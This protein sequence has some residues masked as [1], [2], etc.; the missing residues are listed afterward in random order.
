MVVQRLNPDLV[1]A[2]ITTQYDAERHYVAIGAFPMPHSLHL[3]CFTLCVWCTL[4]IGFDEARRYKVL[5]NAPTLKRPEGL[6]DD[7]DW[8]QYLE[9]NPDLVRAGITTERT[10]IP[11]HQHPC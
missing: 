2:K 4:C 5:Q 10:V 1:R 9:V 6:P 11:H 3:Q 7:F 8:L